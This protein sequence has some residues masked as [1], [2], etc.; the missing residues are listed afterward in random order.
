[1]E[2]LLSAALLQEIVPHP[3]HGGRPTN[4]GISVSESLI[5]RGH[6]SYDRESIFPK[7]VIIADPTQQNY[8]M[9]PRNYYVDMLKKCRTCQRPFIFFAKEQ[10]HWFETL[11]FYVDADCVTCPRCRRDTQTERR[12]LQ[13]YSG[14]VAKEGHSRK[15]LMFLVDDA[16]YLLARGVLRDLHRLGRIK[17]QALRQIPEYSGTAV[18]VQAIKRASGAT[19]DAHQLKI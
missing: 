6:W 1:M 18:L 5:R 4:S 16:I 3:Q 11:K 8:A 2:K 12:R 7:S 17:N 13:R 19:D 15:E 14:L 10:K 9:Y